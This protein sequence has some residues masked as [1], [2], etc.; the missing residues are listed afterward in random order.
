MKNSLFLLFLLQICLTNPFSAQAQLTLLSR[1]DDDSLPVAS[2]N[3]LRL[4]YSSVFGHAIN[5]NE[6][7]IIGGARHILF[8]DITGAKATNPE[9]IG[10]F[11]GTS[12]TVWREF[13]SYKNR[14]YAVSDNTNEGL[15][16][17]DMTNAPDT[18]VRSY[19]SNEFFNSSH[20]ITLDSASGRIFLNG[21]NVASQ[22]LMVLD[23]SQNPD[24]P[25]VL[26]TIPSLEGGYIHDSYVRNDTVYAS[27]GYKGLYV[28]DFKTNVTAPTTITSVTTGGYNH[29]SAI[30]DDGKYLYYSEEIPKG[31]PVQVV[32][33]QT[34][35]TGDI[36]IVHSFLDAQLADP[37]GPLAIPHNV[38]ISGNYLFVSQ[39]ED[40]LLV[41]DIGT[42]PVIPILVSVFDTHPENTVYNGYFGN[43]GNYPWLPSGNILASDM[44]NGL[45]VLKNTVNPIAIKETLKPTLSVQ[46]N[47]NPMSD[48]FNISVETMEKWSYQLTDLTGKI[49]KE[50]RNISE[51]TCTFDAALL[52]K[53]VYFL[54]V[55][56]QNGGFGVQKVVKL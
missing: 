6:I 39:Y 15:M 37:A 17:F 46:V 9:L 48:Y 26:A 29:N 1:W 3:N 11:E 23:V 40:G 28:Y 30:T 45:Y 53:G 41:Y 2:P 54:N 38:F 24:V 35:N 25:T 7:A 27:S 19:W 52:S 4:Q 50:K 10:K 32:D 51:K 8:F 21:S 5:G 49:V 55:Q 31:K 22:G 56:N 20:S 44:Q 16:I 34:I 14:L 43:W 18:I 47:P 13:K 42:N 12:T 33:L 36:S